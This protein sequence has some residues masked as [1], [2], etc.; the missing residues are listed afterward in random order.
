MSLY[1]FT[2]TAGSSAQW[3]YEAM[4]DPA[5]WQPTPRGTVPTAVLLAHSNEVAIRAFAER[6]HNVVRWTEYER[7]GHFFAAE[8][9]DLF[10][11]DLREFFAP[12]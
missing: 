1:W 7:G 2:G 6:D 12:A 11:G 5:G 9:P 10:V 8:E 4:N 3:Y